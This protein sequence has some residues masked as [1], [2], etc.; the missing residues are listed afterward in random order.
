MKAFDVEKYLRRN[1]PPALPPAAAGYRHAAVIPVYNEL[2]DFAAMEHS[3]R[4][5]LASSPEPVAV[6]AVVNYPAGSSSA[7]S[8][9]L[10]RLIG[11]GVFPGV[12][13]LYLP[14][15][16]GGVGGAR[17]AGMDAFIALVPPEEM[18]HRVLFSL[19]ADTLVSP[20]YFADVLPEALRGGAVSI[21][22]SHRPAADAAHQRAIDRYEAYLRRYVEKLRQAG[23]PY[24]FFTVG[25]A[26]AVRC[27]AYLRAGGMKVRHAGE[28]F[29]F[30][31]EA[32]KSSSVRSLEKTL[33][34]PSP[35]ISFRVPFGTGQAVASL[36]RGEELPEIPDPAFSVLAM[37]LAAARDE[38]PGGVERF[39]RRL[40]AAAAEFFLK[41]GF[42]DVWRGILRKR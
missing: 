28:D 10:L 15:F 19:D 17:K 41:E 36:L 11:D 14:E 34:F 20:D 3:L 2:H 39:L 18:E 21:G 4:A 42:P 33:V 38:L 7:E 31:Q 40:P 32:A 8:E 23:S 27:D 5:A 25:S 12:I 16:T 26:F 37:V 22:F 6:I 1:P 24:A 13:P 9:E 30:L 35:R 29:Y